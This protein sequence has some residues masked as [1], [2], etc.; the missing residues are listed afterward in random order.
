LSGGKLG[1][2]GRL[3][4][5]SF[6]GKGADLIFCRGADHIARQ[7]S[8]TRFAL[9]MTLTSVLVFGLWQLD[10]EQFAPVSR[11]VSDWST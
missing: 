4:A 6:F 1:L 11:S 8:S 9:A 7:D 2:A 3:A 5:L 10:A